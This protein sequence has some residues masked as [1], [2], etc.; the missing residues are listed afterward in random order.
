M[1]TDISPKFGSPVGGET[2]TI[3]G[4][5]FGTVNGDVI[6]SID[7]VACVVNGATTATQITCQT[8]A[9]Q[10]TPAMNTFVVT[11]K[12]N[13]AVIKTDIFLYAHKWSS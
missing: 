11:V 9:R 10:S 6:V 8:G 3:T 7:G 4:T 12:S 2:L 13:V 5:G 1:V